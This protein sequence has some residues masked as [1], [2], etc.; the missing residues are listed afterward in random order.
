MGAQAEISC[1]A[2]HRLKRVWVKPPR[3][4]SMS[5]SVALSVWHY[6]DFHGN[7]FYCELIAE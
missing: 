3:F 2:F 7:G 6:L 5:G 1:C 4:W